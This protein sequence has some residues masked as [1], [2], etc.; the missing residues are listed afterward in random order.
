[1]P[2]PVHAQAQAAVSAIQLPPLWAEPSSGTR[3]ELD[4]DAVQQFTL[5]MAEEGQPVQVARMFSD[6]LYAYERIA[7]AHASAH[8]GLRRLALTLFH[9][10]HRADERRRALS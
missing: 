1:M 8:A 3:E 6:R 9:S 10:C 5:L 2:D 7:C 4:I